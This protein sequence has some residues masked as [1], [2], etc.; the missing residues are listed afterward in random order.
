[1]VDIIKI[2]M[3]EFDT[4]ARDSWLGRRLMSAQTISHTIAN[5]SLLNF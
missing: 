5:L 3:I 4:T 2:W 1:M